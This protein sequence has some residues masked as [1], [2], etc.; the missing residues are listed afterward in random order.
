M[1]NEWIKRDIAI[2]KRI[3]LMLAL[4]DVLLLFLIW[5]G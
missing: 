3:V 2:L 4:M 1:E 5:W